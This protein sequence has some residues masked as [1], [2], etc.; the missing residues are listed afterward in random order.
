M[1]ELSRLHIW[2]LPA[3][4]LT[5]H[6]S[7]AL[8]GREVVGFAD[9]AD[10]AAR[11]GEVEALFA[12]HPPRGHWAKA[13]ALRLVQIMGAGV[14]ALLPAPDLP[15][16][17]QIANGRGLSAGV[18][19]EYA[20]GWMLHFARR[21]ERNAE[22]QGRREW[23]MYAPAT[24]EGA[25]CGI[26]GMGAIGEAVAKRAKAFGMR[27]LA[28][29][30]TPRPCEW[31]D[32]VVGPDATERVL[33]ESGYV[34]VILP[35]TDATRGSLAGALLAKMQPEAVL[36]NMARGGIVD[37]SALADLLRDGKL[38]GAA[39]DVFEQE[40]LPADSPLWNVP[41]L[42]VTPHMAGFSTDYL[43]RSFAIFAENVRRLECGE[44]LL[45]EVDRHRGY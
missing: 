3:A 12:L 21:V 23:R 27:V 20:L 24:L 40:P 43:P 8:P 39:V 22:Q 26:L 15:G 38:R 37:E 4:L 25:T 16:T 35:L 32:E 9:E 7:T 33:S 14:D 34:V 28:T 10:F 42:V 6:I 2:G 13:D 17:V 36:I 18:M 29:Q 5:P 31:A 30:R 41:N 1:P 45:N 44:S 19:A 11:I